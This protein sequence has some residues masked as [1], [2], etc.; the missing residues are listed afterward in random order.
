MVEWYH[1]VGYNCILAIMPTIS[2]ISG[3]DSW[4]QNP[5]MYPIETCTVSR[6][7]TGI[8]EGKPFTHHICPH[9][10]CVVVWEP[11]PQFAGL[12]A[13]IRGNLT[14]PQT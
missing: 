3:A 7:Y 8:K 13:L 10:N 9:H 4:A 14:N 1:C 12:D 5:W 11:N 2:F 6:D